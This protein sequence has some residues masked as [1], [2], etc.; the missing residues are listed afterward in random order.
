MKK[1][2]QVKHKKKTKK[3]YFTVFNVHKPEMCDK[4]IEGLKRMNL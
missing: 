1:T 2:L 3:N 4:K